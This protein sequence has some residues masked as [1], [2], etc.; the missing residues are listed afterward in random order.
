MKGAAIML[1]RKLDAIY[2]TA[3]WGRYW[4]NNGIPAFVF[5]LMEGVSASASYY[6]VNFTKL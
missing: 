6:C 1:K 3:A 4:F 5:P 2:I